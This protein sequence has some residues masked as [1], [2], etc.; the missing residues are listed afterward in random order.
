MPWARAR[1]D[2][3]RQ[4]IRPG[5]VIAFGGKGGFAG[6]IKWA[7]LG[8]INHVAIVMPSQD[9]GEDKSPVE[10]SDQIIESTSALDKYPGVNIRQL[11][12][13]VEDH[14]GQVWWLPL[15]EITRQKLDLGK[16]GAFLLQ[17]VGKG[18][19]SQQALKS[20]PDLVEDA[21]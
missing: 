6:V 20:A 13:R 5:D 19:D 14:E 4:E 9:Q 12:E 17:Q 1:Y 10:W 7:T 15:S 21:A 8:P 11:E 16:L 18:Y 2:D 3:V